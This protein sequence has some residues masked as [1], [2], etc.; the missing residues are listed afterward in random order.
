MQKLAV[1]N[2]K[3]SLNN[4]LTPNSKSLERTFSLSE[5]KARR[6]VV[7]LNVRLLSSRVNVLQ[8]ERHKLDRTINDTKVKA[9]DI[10]KRRLEK[11]QNQVYIVDV[12]LYFSS[13]FFL[14]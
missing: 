3:P 12:L 10:F 8:Q 6:K 4:S 7:E 1:P 2:L 14:T 11:E 5:I 13:I 9:R